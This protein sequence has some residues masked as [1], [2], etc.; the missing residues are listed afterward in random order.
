[1]E[2]L[3]LFAKLS[4]SFLLAHARFLETSAV[5]MPSASAPSRPVRP[6]G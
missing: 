4:E 5:S 6:L 1:M 3:R 2:K